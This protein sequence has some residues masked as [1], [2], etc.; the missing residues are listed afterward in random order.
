MKHFYVCSYGGCGSTLLANSLKQFGKVYH[1]HSKNP[2]TQLEYVGD[3]CYC[4]WFNGIK[5]PDNELHEYYVIYIY[6]N[7]VKSIISR[8]TNPMHL[9]HIQSD[10]TIKLIDVVKSQTDL[11][12]INE[13][14]NNYTRNNNRNYKIYCIRYENMFENQNEISKLFGI[15]NL[16][17]IKKESNTPTKHLNI[18]N[19]IYK[20]LNDKMQSNNWLMI[21]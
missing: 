17:L 6:K 10:Q 8:F 3:I 7:P 16:K 18:L 4:E 15:G 5:I 11:Y 20:D 21:I 12:K 13:F 14:Y 9:L 19:K 2:P 1:I